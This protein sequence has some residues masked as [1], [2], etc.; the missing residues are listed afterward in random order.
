MAKYMGAKILKKKL[1]AEKKKQARL[2]AERADKR[3]G[4]IAN[5]GE[6]LDRSKQ[7]F[8]MARGMSMGDDDFE[9]ISAAVDLNPKF[10]ATY[11]LLRKST[12]SF[13]LTLNEDM[14]N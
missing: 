12:Q 1:E 9:K 5:Q 4:I 14:V 8:N 10:S 3:G 7:K 6:V 2:D 11:D 13:I